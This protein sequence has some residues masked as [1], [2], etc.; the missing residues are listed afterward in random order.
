MVF[1]F[2]SCYDHIDLFQ[3]LGELGVYAHTDDNANCC[4]WSRKRIREAQ[5]QQIALGS[6]RDYLVTPPSSRT[7]A[8]HR[9]TPPTISRTRGGVSKFPL[10][11][12][13]SKQL[14]LYSR[15]IPS[16]EVASGLGYSTAVHAAQ[17]VETLSKGPTFSEEL[18]AS[19]RLGGDGE[20]E[21]V[22]M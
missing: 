16:M 14:F 6:R 2:T 13:S 3:S 18:V 22:P 7:A 9:Y 17:A 11:S 19:G 8:H 20:V 15:Q 1:D 12:P 10:T 5:Q 21:T 4:F